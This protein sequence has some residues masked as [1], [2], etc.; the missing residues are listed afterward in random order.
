MLFSRFADRQTLATL[1]LVSKLFA[2]S[3]TLYERLFGLEHHN[4]NLSQIQCLS[5]KE[6]RTQRILAERNLLNGLFHQEL[7]FT[8]PPEALHLETWALQEKQFISYWVEQTNLLTFFLYEV[9]KKKT[10]SFTIPL[11]FRIRGFFASFEELDG[12]M[13]VSITTFY[14]NQ[15]TFFLLKVDDGAL[16]EIQRYTS[17]E[18]FSSFK[19]IFCKNSQSFRL[20]MTT[21]NRLQISTT[22]TSC[23]TKYFAT[24]VFIGG[25]FFWDERSLLMLHYPG[26]EPRD[27]L[28]TICDFDTLEDCFYLETPWLPVKR[29]AKV[30]LQDKKLTVFQYN[31]AEACVFEIP[32][33][34]KTAVTYRYSCKFSA[35][36]N[37]LPIYLKDKLYYM[38]VWD[39]SMSCCRNIGLANPNSLEFIDVYV[40]P[41]ETNLTPYES[42]GLPAMLA[43]DGKQVYVLNY[44]FTPTFGEECEASIL[45]VNAFIHRFWKEI[46]SIFCVFG[47]LPFLVWKS[48][49]SPT[50]VKGSAIT[51][52]F[53][54][55]IA[56]R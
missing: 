37:S 51:L 33:F 52:L 50:I 23:N 46:L 27:D 32:S 45:K 16:T 20:A 43:D 40:F 2:S 25:H 1:R 44:N 9:Q 13:H 39:S 10:L 5:W 48:V 3:E 6:R 14:N 54:A 7:I 47:L 56:N 15:R 34:P 36:A 8:P 49:I 19:W 26:I 4:L 21:E 17:N 12:G 22:P 24:N 42:Q 18:I 30:L 38:S 29:K 53:F 41:T 31:T 28:I 55:V 35:S 11:A